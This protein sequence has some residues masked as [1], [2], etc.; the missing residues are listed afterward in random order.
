MVIAVIPFI[1]LIVGLLMWILAA[2]PKVA[3]AGRL[4]FFCGLFVLTMAFSR[5]TVSIG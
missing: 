5:Q 3:E 2:H 1:I 4:M